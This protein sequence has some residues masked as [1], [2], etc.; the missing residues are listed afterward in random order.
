M[1]HPPTVSVLVLNRNGRQYLDTCLSSLEAQEYPADRLT[2]EVVDNGSAD[3]SIEFVRAHHPRVHVLALGT[4]HGFAGGYNI[5]VRRAA[6]DFVAFLNN[7]TRV[8]PHW[9]MELVSA[10]DR[11]GAAAV[12]SR[13]LD[14]EGERVDFA[15]GLLSFSGHA[16]QRGFGESAACTYNEDRLLFACAGSALMDRAA[17]LDA[18]GFDDEFFAYFEDVDLG[19]RLNL[20]GHTIV[21]APRA[22][23]YHRLHGSFSQLAFTQ[24]L[25]LFERNALAMIYKNYEASTLERVLPVA[26]ALSLT[27]GLMRSGIDTLALD[28]SSTPPADVAVDRRLIAHLIALEDFCSQL[29][30]LARKRDWIQRRRRRSDADLFPLFGDPRRLHE[31]GTIYESIAQALVR[32]FGID[33]LLPPV[34]PVQHAAPPPAAG[35]P[36]PPRRDVQS[37]V[38]RI[39]VVILTALGDTHLQPC[40]T[41]LRAQT[42]PRDRFEVIVV[43]NGSASQVTA[44]VDTWCPGV[45]VIRNATN[46]GF[47]VGNNVGARQATGDFIVFLNDDT[48]AHCDCLR[49]LVATAG[50]HGAAAVAGC[51]L[52]WEGKAADFVGGGINFEGKGFQIDYGVARESLGLEERPLLFACGGAMLVDRSVFLQAGGWDDDA[53][54]YYE[55]VELGWRLNML[56]QSAW[57]SPGAIVYHKHHGTSAGWPD[58]PRQRLY[59]R[60]S[61]RM[62]YALL[63]VRSLERVLPAALLLAADRALLTTGLSRASDAAA[64]SAAWPRRTV[65]QAARSAKIALRTHGISRQMSIAA[66]LRRLGLRGLLGVLGAMAAP[67]VP[68]AAGQRASYLIERG[69]TPPAL[70][71]Y[72]ERIPIAAA[73]VLSGV[74]GFLSD[75][76]RLSSRRQGLQDRR[77]RTDEEIL[78]AFGTHWT[79]ACG[80]PYQPEHTSFQRALVDELGIADLARPK[81]H[82]RSD[83][84]RP[85][86]D[87]I[88][89]TGATG[90]T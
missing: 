75:L 80:A 44:R 45:R 47:A 17:F 11:H 68:G 18:G 51:M 25:R 35:A 27:R 60:N 24:R 23:T 21:L 20:L 46:L 14:W 9:L 53:F 72:S 33:E 77:R 76:P 73:A 58:A 83:A 28:F 41:S 42:Y 32:D 29:P 82:A 12:A 81:T 36:P 43:D 16:W 62:L 2:I 5:A 52:D 66:A 8:D 26:V 4:N 65:H 13:M 56:G 31:T 38:P 19:W 85:A 71:A 69:S 79:E 57:L 1:T 7:D 40:L 54:A 6:T 34:A 30:A 15:G 67:G 48:R 74:Y 39:S 63:E 84:S 55:D 78:N 64:R 59:E 49:E 90:R 3:D 87:P 88:G 61:L 22:I 50:R 70:D 89:V 10:A 37:A 86:R